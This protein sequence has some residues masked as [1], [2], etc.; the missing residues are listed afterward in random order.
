M[1]LKYLLDT[2]SLSYVVSN[3][4]PEVRKRF[5]EHSDETG[6]SAISF[7]EALFGARKKKASKLESLIRVFCDMVEILPFS[8]AA[9]ECYAEIRAQLETG[10]TPIGAMDMLIAAAAKSVG[11]VLVTN[12]VRHFSKID[13]L[14]IEDWVEKS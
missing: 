11:A 4:H 12:N 2:D 6:I 9:A 7:A 8:D 10:G 13:G 1:A 14:S 3:R 5:L